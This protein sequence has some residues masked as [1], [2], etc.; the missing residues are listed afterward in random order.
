MVYEVRRT[1]AMVSFPTYSTEK[2]G[3]G[4]L[5]ELP[6]RLGCTYLNC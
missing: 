6:S 3:R 5:V 4:K 1:A 2:S